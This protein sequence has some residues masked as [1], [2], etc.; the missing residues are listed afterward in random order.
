MATMPCSTA[1]AYTE[2]NARLRVTSQIIGWS[3]LTA[4]VVLA[5]AGTFRS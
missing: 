5:L 4:A 3:M 2:E 1:S